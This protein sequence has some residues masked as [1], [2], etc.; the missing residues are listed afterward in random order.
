[1]GI[2]CEICCNYFDETE[3]RPKNLPCG[4]TFCLACMETSF[5]NGNKL[6]HLCRTPHKAETIDNL[7]FNFRLEELIRSKYNPLLCKTEEDEGFSHGKC[8]KHANNELLF[9]CQTHNLYIC[10]KCILDD[11]KLGDCQLK[12][13]KGEFLERKTT[14]KEQ[15]DISI[16]ICETTIKSLKGKICIKSNDI[17]SATK[18]IG[19]LQ[20]LINSKKEDIKRDIE[21]Q[22]MLCTGG[23]HQI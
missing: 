16:A 15:V 17:Q 3:R 8:F 19:R 20:S 21:I 5:A 23:P 6:C 22:D 1:A 7:P 12:S 13:Y 4:H 14:K 10:A 2:E 11:H 9:L 18:E